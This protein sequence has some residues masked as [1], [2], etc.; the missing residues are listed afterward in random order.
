MPFDHGNTHWINIINIKALCWTGP[1]G[2]SIENGIVSAFKVSMISPSEKKKAI[3]NL[4]IWN[5][6]SEREST[7]IHEF[8]HQM[9]TT[10]PTRYWSWDPG[11]E[12]RPPTY[13]FPSFLEKAKNW[14][15][16]TIW[17]P[18]NRQNW[19][20]DNWRL[21]SLPLSCELFKDKACLPSV[22]LMPDTW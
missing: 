5:A 17:S 19:G 13:F 10:A 22:T 1:K 3:K 8:T 4:F 12:S 16:I 20:S 7:L 15:R 21:N 18:W 9:A 11:T 6:K 14:L 2:H